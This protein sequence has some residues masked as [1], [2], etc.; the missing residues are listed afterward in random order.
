MLFAI[1]DLITQNT[2]KPGLRII[3]IRTGG[4]QGLRGFNE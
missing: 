1:Y 4:L 2:F 3:A